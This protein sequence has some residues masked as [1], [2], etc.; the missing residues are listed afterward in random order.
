[1]PNGKQFYSESEANEILQL[2]ANAGGGDLLSRE[3]LLHAGAELGISPEEIDRAAAQIAERRNANQEK[4]AYRRYRRK[5][6]SADV[7]TYLSV[8]AVCIGIWFFSGRG[9]FWPQWV[10]GI[11]GL[12]LC[13]EV[14]KKLIESDDEDF[15][16]WK[17]T[18]VPRNPALTTPEVTHFIENLGPMGKIEAIKEIRNRF[19][20]DLKDSKDIADEHQ[21][22]HPGA[23]A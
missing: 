8:C 6:I 13:I 1:M 21:R 2:A 9:D 4:Q 10:I 18:R 22:T 17:R 14:F 15:Q 12:L 11:W 5:S 16:K 19:G 3:Q 7:F 23:F 20:F